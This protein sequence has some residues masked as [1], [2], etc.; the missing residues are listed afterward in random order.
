MTRSAPSCWKMPAIRRSWP[1]SSK[2]CNRCSSPLGLL[3]KAWRAIKWLWRR[4]MQTLFGG[5]WSGQVADLFHEILQSDLSY[6]S[7]VLLCMGQDKGDGVLVAEGRSPGYPLAAEVQHAALSGHCGLR[8]EIQGVCRFRF[9]YAAAD[10]DMADAE[11]HHGTSAGRLCP[12][13]GSGAGSGQ[14]GQMTGA[15]YSATRD[16][17]L[18]MVRSCRERWVP[19]RRQPSPRFPNG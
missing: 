12:G 10:M 19:I 9:L 1:G 7:S 15:R 17:T 3:K 6:R 13:A 14:C 2:A 8:Q 16:F 4:V 11:Q 5:K 18:R